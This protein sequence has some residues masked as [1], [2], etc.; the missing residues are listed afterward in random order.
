MI[1]K[2]NENGYRIFAFRWWGILLQI[3]IGF[4]FPLII[5]ETCFKNFVPILFIA[6]CGLSNILA[7]FIVKKVCLQPMNV[8]FD[9][10]SIALEYLSEDLNTVKKSQKI[11]LKYIVSF[12]DYSFR[13]EPTFKL[14]L[15]HGF[16]I[17]FHKND[18]WNKKDDFEILIEDFKK[19]IENYNSKNKNAETLNIGREL[20]IEYQDFFKQQKQKLYFIFR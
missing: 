18:L 5:S 16:Y 14:I 3:F 10:E 13:G 17:S 1:D 2:N 12:S 7:F 8:R 4:I 9:D 11:L 15:Q 6:A 20:K 19:H